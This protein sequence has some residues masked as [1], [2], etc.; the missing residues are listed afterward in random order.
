MYLLHFIALLIV[1]IY[2]I[3]YIFTNVKLYVF[4]TIMCDQWGSNVKF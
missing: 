2:V 1:C 4:N 3:F